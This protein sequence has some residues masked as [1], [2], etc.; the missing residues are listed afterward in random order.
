MQRTKIKWFLLALKYEIGSSNYNY[1]CIKD[2]SKLVRHQLTKIMEKI[3]ICKHS[4]SFIL[5]LNK[6]KEHS[7]KCK[8]YSLAKTI[9]P[10]DNIIKF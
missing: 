10:T 1:C 4:I 7:K 3:K 2:F 5:K 8:K 6:L 9:I